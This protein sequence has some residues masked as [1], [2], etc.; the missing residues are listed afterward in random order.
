VQL[1]SVLYQK[2][3]EQIGLMNQEINEWMDRHHF[4]TTK[5]FIGK[6]SYKEV[7]NPAAYE[8]VQFMKHFAGIE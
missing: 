8:R 5:E 3:L 1:A 4:A 2:G 7:E 6:M